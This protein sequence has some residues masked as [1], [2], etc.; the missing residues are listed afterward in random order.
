MLRGRESTLHGSKHYNTRL[1][2][3]IGKE[4]TDAKADLY[5]CF[6]QRNADLAEAQRL[7]RYDHHPE[8]D[9]SVQL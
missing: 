4:Y 3:F 2:T 1:K 7:R 8:L 6:I 9:V 5:A